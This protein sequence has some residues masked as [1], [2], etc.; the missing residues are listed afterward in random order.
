MIT[1]PGR[2]VLLGHPVA[3]SLS[4]AFQNAALTAAR[5]PLLYQAVDVSSAH[6]AMTLARLV[7]ENAAGN[8]TI[9]HKRTV[10]RACAELTAQAERVGAVNTFAVRDGTLVGHN[11]DVAGFDQAVKALL[12]AAPKGLTIGVFGAGGAA[13]AVLAAIESWS[14]CSA[15]VANRDATRAAMICE[16]F[17]SVAQTGDAGSIAQQADIVVNATSL[18]MVAG[19]RGPVDPANL[20]RATAVLDLV[21]A[22]GETVFV[23]AA[24]DRGI[25]AGDGLSMLVAQGAEAFTWWFGRR[26]DVEVMWQAVGRR[27]PGTA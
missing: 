15:I 20:R 19:E 13:A 14:D 8:V 7:E 27:P 22:P 25:R 1:L 2:L 4:P 26:P 21:Y 9:P 24:R 6:L 11:T 18:G 3:H 16:R 10:A 5:I 12:G 17:R 23:R